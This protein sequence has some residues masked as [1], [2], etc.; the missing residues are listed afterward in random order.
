MS[1]R[2]RLAGIAR[3][4]HRSNQN[5]VPSSIQYVRYP[6]SLIWI[7]VIGY[8]ASKISWGYACPGRNSGERREGSDID[9]RTITV[10]RGLTSIFESP[11]DRKPAFAAEPCVE[12]AESASQLPAAGVRTVARY[13]DELIRLRGALFQ[14][15]A[16]IV[17]RT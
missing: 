6:T 1:T 5:S 2:P 15:E 14:E 13:A 10:Q 4:V 8:L 12:S 7:N 16:L 17:E 3:A 11:Y 9:H